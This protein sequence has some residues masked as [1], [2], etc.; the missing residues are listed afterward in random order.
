V[1]KYVITG[2]K[3]CAASAFSLGVARRPQTAPRNI[4]SGLPVNL[5]M[6]SVVSLPAR[7]DVREAISR[8]P[9]V[10]AAR[11]RCSEPGTIL[12]QCKR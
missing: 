1:E 6:D 7:L 11:S 3:Q 10:L 2:V 8:L 12:T 9:G 5:H 4:A